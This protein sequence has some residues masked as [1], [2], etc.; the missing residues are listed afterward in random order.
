MPNRERSPNYPG[1]SLDQ[2]VQMLRDLYNSEHRTAVSAEVAARALG[3]AGV[4]EKGRL[5]GPAL[6]KLAVLRQFGLT[7]PAD[8]G[9][10]KVADSALDFVLHGPGE[11]EYQA[12]AQKAAL[13]PPIF[14]ELYPEYA[15]AS[16]N[17]LRAH[18]IKERKFSDEG[19]NR[20]IKS[21]RD[22]IAFAKLDG[23]SYPDSKGGSEIRE[24]PPKPPGGAGLRV[25]QKPPS[26]REDGVAYSWPLGDGNK[27][28]LAFSAEPTQ[29]QLDVM[30][31]QLRIMRDVAPAMSDAQRQA[32]ADS[33]ASAQRMDHEEGMVDED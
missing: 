13:T 16:D 22:T 30:M 4:S 10:I 15:K 27:V 14:G 25:D 33:R 26:P 23:T 20:L 7:V 11:P 21:F 1:Y 28:E 19:A 6:A 12:A 18:L 24:K 3:H 17:A 9:K 5:S 31:A 32:L 2:A 29:K 8:K